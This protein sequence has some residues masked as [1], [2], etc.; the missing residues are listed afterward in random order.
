MVS[1]RGGMFLKDTES[2]AAII[3]QMADKRLK[4][5]YLS[6]GSLSLEAAF[7]NRK[8]VVYTLVDGRPERIAGITLGDLEVTRRGGPTLRLTYNSKEVEV[9]VSPTKIGDREIFLQIPQRFELK[10]TGKNTRLGEV[11]FVPHYA[12]L[13]KSRSKEFHQ[14]DQHTYCVTLNKFRERFPDLDFRF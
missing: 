10:W 7:P 5:E 14:V 11:Q 6:Y 4:A 9:G 12:V 1:E 13:V 2:L 8:L 3:D